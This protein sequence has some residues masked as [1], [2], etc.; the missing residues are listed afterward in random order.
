MP[1][2]DRSADHLGFVGPEFDK[3]C[4]DLVEMTG[5]LE[6]AQLEPENAWPGAQFQRLA[7]SGVLQWVIPRQYGGLELSTEDLM[8][9]YERLARA[10][11]VTTFVLTQRNGACQRIAGGENDELKSELLPALATGELFATV[12]VSHLTTSRQHL[13][14]PAMEVRPQGSGFVFHGSAPWVTGAK[15]ADY[16]VTGGT[17]EDGKQVLAAV[18]TACEGIQVG[19]PQQLLALNASQTGPVRMD[20]VEIDA[21]HVIAGPVEQVMKRGKGGGAGSLTTSALALGTA[22]GS[23]RRLKEEADKRADLVEVYEPLAAEHADILDNMAGALRGES[24]EENPAVSTES[25]RKR[26]NSLVVRSAQAYLAACKGA[27][28]VA[29]HPAERAVRESM[30]FLVWSCPQPVLTAALREF[31]CLAD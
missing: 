3:L 11:L 15:F 31:A 8:W 28:F 10:C 9:G 5:R 18:P 16:I 13:R 4:D 2:T 1:D 25:I 12:G 6:T 17:C 29:G 20:N 21:N 26:A 24:G 22:G 30:F 23:L 7:E 27:G 19:E 14:K